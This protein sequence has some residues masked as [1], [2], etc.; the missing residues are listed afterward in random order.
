MGSFAPD[1]DELNLLDDLDA[2]SIQSLPFFMKSPTSDLD[3]M[4]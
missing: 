4:S 3:A 2:K 1:D